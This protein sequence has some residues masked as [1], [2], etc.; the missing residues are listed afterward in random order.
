MELT[1]WDEYV[2]RCWERSR[3][4]LSAEQEEQE[5]HGFRIEPQAGGVVLATI[6]YPGARQAQAVEVDLEHVRATDSVRVTY[7]FPRNGWSVLQASRFAWDGDD[8]DCDPDW[9]EVAF[10]PSWGRE[11]RCPKCEAGLIF[12]SRT[13]KDCGSVVAAGNPELLRQAVNDAAIDRLRGACAARGCDPDSALQEI[14]RRA[15]TGH[16]GFAAESDD[17]VA[18]I[19][20]QRWPR[21]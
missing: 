15:E 6:L 13:C 10:V 20:A 21:G 5:S 8:P 1:P 19:L 11:E 12:P 16:R 2:T 14:I 18:E 3:K 7:D 9:R 4:G 17:L